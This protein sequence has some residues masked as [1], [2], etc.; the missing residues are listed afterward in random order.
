MFGFRSSLLSSGAT[1]V[2]VKSC[3]LPSKGT[4]AL[5]AV[6]AAARGFCSATSDHVCIF[7]PLGRDKMYSK[8]NTSSAL[9]FAEITSALFPDLQTLCWCYIICDYLYPSGAIEVLSNRRSACSGSPNSASMDATLPTLCFTTD[10][11]SYFP[12]LGGPNAAS[13]ITPLRLIPS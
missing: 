12:P 3:A 10:R 6:A 1:K 2:I 9:R 8:A 5:A 13:G 11:F 7:I 4:P